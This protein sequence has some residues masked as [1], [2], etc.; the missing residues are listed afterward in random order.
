MIPPKTWRDMYAS[1]INRNKAVYVGT[2]S[3]F[4]LLRKDNRLHKIIWT[5]QNVPLY[6]NKR[7]GFMIDFSKDFVDELKWL[8]NRVDCRRTDLNLNNYLQGRWIHREDDRHL[9]HLALPQGW[10]LQVTDE[11]ILEINPKVN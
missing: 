6:Y 10:Y 8:N 2:T 1:I 7:K 5:I 3:V 4:F 9:K 11:E